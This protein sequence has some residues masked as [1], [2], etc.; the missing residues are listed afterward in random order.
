M[1]GLQQGFAIRGMRAT[2]ISHIGKSAYRHVAMG[3]SLHEAIK[4]GAT[5]CPLRSESDR[6]IA[7][8]RNDVTG[9]LRHFALRKSVQ[10][11]L[12]EIR[13]NEARETSAPR[14]DEFYSLG[15]L[16]AWTEANSAR[17]KA[18]SVLYFC[19]R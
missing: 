2:I 6:I 16:V 9:Q 13:A 18:K 19:R 10:Q 12:S 4:S 3:H 11:K 5:R 17:I 15:L 14:G 8:P 1:T 7:L